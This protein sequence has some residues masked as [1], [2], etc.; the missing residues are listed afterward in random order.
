MWNSRLGHAYCYSCWLIEVLKLRLIPRLRSRTPC[1]SFNLFP[2]FSS[3]G[4]SSH[5]SPGPSVTSVTRNTTRLIQLGDNS[6][7]QTHWIP[8]SFLSGMSPRVKGLEDESWYINVIDSCCW[9]SCWGN[10]EPAVQSMTIWGWRAGKQPWV[11]V[12]RESQ[13]LKKANGITSRELHYSK[14]WGKTFV[15]KQIY[16]N[17]QINH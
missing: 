4:F 10:R 9:L 17:N 5:T 14:L 7:S 13:W 8:F 11:E 16:R 3:F 6:S 15:L 2:F 12:L 1:F